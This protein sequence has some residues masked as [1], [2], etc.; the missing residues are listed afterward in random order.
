VQ[1]FVR[2]AVLVA[3]L[4]ALAGCGAGPGGGPGTGVERVVVAERTD[5]APGNAS[6]VDASA[7]VLADADAVQAALTEAATEGD[8]RAIVRV[9][10]R[11]FGALNRTLAAIPGVADRS[12]DEAVAATLY[13]AYEGDVYRVTVR[14]RWLV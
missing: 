1:R 8:E 3:V 9:S 4:V 11:R 14:K 2:G 7:P 5:L 12:G 6:T 13:V 10:E